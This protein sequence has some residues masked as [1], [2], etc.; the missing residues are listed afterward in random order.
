LGIRAAET[1]PYDST[2]PALTGISWK[3]ASSLIQGRRVH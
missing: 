2:R 3:K 1:K